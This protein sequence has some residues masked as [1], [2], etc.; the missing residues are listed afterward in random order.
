[1]EPG[2]ITL[3]VARR[4]I[5]RS[6]LVTEEEI[7]EAMRRVRHAKGWLME[8]AAGVAVAAFLKTADRYKGKT[9]AIVICGGNVSSEVQ[10]RI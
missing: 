6:L 9:V 5:D 4:V 10:K 3:E 1:L 7:L 2:A 8:G